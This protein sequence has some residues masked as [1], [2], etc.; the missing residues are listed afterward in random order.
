MTGRVSL[1]A[2][3]LSLLTLGAG[4]HLLLECP[5]VLSGALLDTAVFTAQSRGFDVLLAH[6]ERSPD[7]VGRVER[8]AELVA[9]GAHV[10]LTAGSLAGRFGRVVQDFALELF[11]RGLVHV[12]ASDAHGAHQRGPD[13]QRHFDAIASRLPDVAA[14]R[15]WWTQT[16]PAAIASGERVPEPPHVRPRRRRPLLRRG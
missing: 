16:A 3:Q 5:F 10:Q 1:P 2:E 6:P 13:M 11:E 12:V 9:R 8:V 14:Q 4:R 7:F 15:E